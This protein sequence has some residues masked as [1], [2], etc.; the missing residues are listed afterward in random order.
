MSNPLTASLSS[1][2]KVL[3]RVAGR[4]VT[5]GPEAPSKALCVKNLITSQSTLPGLLCCSSEW[6]LKRLD[7]LA[8]LPLSLRS[9]AGASRG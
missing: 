9:P 7:V 5:K 6:D 1:L 4:L 3:L 2:L 8:P